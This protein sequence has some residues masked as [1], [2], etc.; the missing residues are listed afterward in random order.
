MPAFDC[1]AETMHVELWLSSIRRYW[2]GG[3]A[4]VANAPLDLERS[5]CAVSTD[6]LLFLR[7]VRRWLVTFCVATA[8]SES[9]S[10]RSRGLGVIWS[11]TTSLEAENGAQ[12]KATNRDPFLC[13]FSG[14]TS[15]GMTRLGVHVTDHAIWNVFGTGKHGV[16]RTRKD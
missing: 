8:A 14:L 2:T 1:R 15:S 5:A 13:V 11:A 9:T 4:E 6:R 10:M 7:L 16:W 3:G 12:A